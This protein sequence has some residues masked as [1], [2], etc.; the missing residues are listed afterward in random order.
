MSTERKDVRSGEKGGG[1]LMRKRWGSKRDTD[2]GKQQCRRDNSNG[3]RQT[4]RMGGISMNE[5]SQ[6]P[7]STRKL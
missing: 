1:D 3:M 4:G 6:T 2:R 7:L 5:I